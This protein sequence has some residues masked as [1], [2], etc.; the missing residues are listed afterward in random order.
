MPPAAGSAS[1]R[2]KAARTAP[3]PENQNAGKQKQAH[4]RVTYQEKAYM[5]QWLEADGGKNFRWIQG[6]LSAGLTMG[7]GNG[8]RPIEGYN[9]MAKFVNV[10]CKY[11]AD[12]DKW[13]KHDAKA[14]YASF[15]RKYMNYR[16]KI[17]S[18][19]GGVTDEDR[20]A[21][22]Q[23]EEQKHDS[24][25]P[26]FGR[27]EMLH[28]HRQNVTPAHV[29]DSAAPVQN[30]ATASD[31]D[32]AASGD[33]EERAEFE[34]DE[35]VTEED[36][37]EESESNMVEGRVGS[38]MEDDVPDENEGFGGAFYAAE[39]Y[40]DENEADVG[41]GADEERGRIEAN[42]NAFGAANLG[43]VESPIVQ[44]RGAS[45]AKRGSG[46]AR[47]RG[48]GGN[49]GGG[50]SHSRESSLSIESTPSTQKRDFNSAFAESSNTRLEVEQRRLQMQLT[51][52]AQTMKREDERVKAERDLKLYEFQ[53]ADRR[54]EREDARLEK[55]LD[56]EE[57]L[58]KMEAK[59][60]RELK[61][62]EMN[63]QT[64]QDR[65]KYAAQLMSQGLTVSQAEESALRLF[66]DIRLSIE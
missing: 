42:L 22:I 14:R 26:F 23:T 36:D 30:N 39:D 40:Y 55:R 63:G 45:R 5:V 16:S 57:K 25:C 50:Q 1:A 21:G 13:D 51:M 18:S 49:R 56:S 12:S 28:G 43:I 34:S 58:K 19:G 60:N 46:A 37:G 7:H 48:R 20:A 62:M 52:H 15:K 66:P 29:I 10:S 59:A 61:M 38:G 8:K 2:G 3:A 65:A 44:Q 24:N 17:P 53:V 11:T 6:E 41:R 32:G 33:G 64:R 27:M 9:A 4:H 31:E 35:G 47:G 54:E